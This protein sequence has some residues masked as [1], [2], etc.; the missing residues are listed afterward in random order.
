LNKRM[1]QIEDRVSGAE[2]DIGSLI[3]KN[4]DQ[5]KGNAKLWDKIMDLEAK[6]RHKNFRIFGVPEGDEKEAEHMESFVKDLIAQLMPLIQGEA[7]VVE[8][9]HRTL[10]TRPEVGQRP[11]VIVAKL[12]NFKLKEEIL[13]LARE[14]RNFEW[15]K[16]QR[17]QIFQDLP[18][19]LIDRRRKFHGVRKICREHGLQTGFRYP[20]ILL[21]T[22]NRQT[23]RFTDEEE[24]RDF[25]RD[26]PPIMEACR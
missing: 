18:K 24:A 17:F 21:I 16:G 7:L 10:Q 2:F 23:H 20:A 5:V 14:A 19:E 6:S 22:K 3:R 1:E 15:N 13:K 4:E 26:N 25:L 11:R 9:A 12:Q 8:R